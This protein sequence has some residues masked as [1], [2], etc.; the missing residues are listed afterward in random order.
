[1]DDPRDRDRRDRDRDRWRDRNRDR[2]RDRDR[3]RRGGGGLAGRRDWRRHQRGPEASGS[4]RFGSSSSSN[5][6]SNRSSQ[7]HK[8]MTNAQRKYAELQQRIRDTARRKA[9]SAKEIETVESMI[10]RARSWVLPLDEAT[11]TCTYFQDRNKRWPFTCTKRGYD[12]LQRLLDFNTELL[13]VNKKLIDSTRDPRYTTM[14]GEGIYE[15]KPSLKC[16]GTT[17]SQEEYGHP[18]LQRMYLLLKSFQRFTE[19]YAT[20]ERAEAA[21]LLMRTKHRMNPASCGLPVLVVVRRTSCLRSSFF[22]A[23]SIRTSS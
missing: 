3:G 11:G 22:S 15:V 18:G 10:A 16:F 20:L 5:N 2:D 19:T 13:V 7:H 6:S 4:G 8:P 23:K 9:D 14:I 17:W 1:M 21:G 12:L